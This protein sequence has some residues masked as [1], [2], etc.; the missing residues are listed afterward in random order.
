MVLERS[1][2]MK[3]V[4]ILMLVLGMASLANAGIV[5]VT[6]DMVSASI[7]TDPIDVAVVQQAHFVGVTGA[8]AISNELLLYGGNLAAFTDFTGADPDLTAGVDF[9]IGEYVAANAGFAGG[10][11]TKIYFAEYF[12][13]T[14]PPADVI[15]QLVTFDVGAPGAEVYLI[16]PD[17]ATGVFSA[18]VIPE[19]ITFALLGLGGLF[20]RRRK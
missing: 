20:L 3:K 13:S 1:K 12:D 10:P 9:W 14:D 7:E 8:G 2:M 6:P 16:D 4:L 5:V 17:L 19:P 11:S 18:V 15:G